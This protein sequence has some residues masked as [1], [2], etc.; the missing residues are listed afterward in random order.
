ME[1]KIDFY[2]FPQLAD[3]PFLTKIGLLIEK[4]YQD[5]QKILVNLN[6]STEAEEFNQFLWTFKDLSFIPHRLITENRS[7]APVLLTNRYQIT[8]S[9]DRD[10]FVNLAWYLPEQDFPWSSFNKIID[11]VGEK[12]K[13]PARERYRFY[14][15]LGKVIDHPS[16]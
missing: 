9:H 16:K 7:D 6:D 14:K 13:Q 2:I 8:P 12:N 1:L 11:F 3:K 15:T 10:C 4:L 5:Q